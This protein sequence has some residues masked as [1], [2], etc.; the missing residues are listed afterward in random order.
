MLS[1]LNDTLYGVKREHPQR[2]KDVAAFFEQGGLYSAFVDFNVVEN[3]AQ[4]IY[5]GQ[6]GLSGDDGAD[7]AL[8]WSLF[9]LKVLNLFDDDRREL[10]G[11]QA[12]DA[13]EEDGAVIVR[14]KIGLPSLQKFLL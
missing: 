1:P 7:R 14:N 9:L 8:H 5:L 11:S 3:S 10:L 12:V 13:V 2:V 4:V 6:A